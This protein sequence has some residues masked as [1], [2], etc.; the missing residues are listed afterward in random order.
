LDLNNS[1]AR[2]KNVKDAIKWCEILEKEME[3]AKQTRT[4]IG[5]RGKFELKS[6][7]DGLKETI[8]FNWRI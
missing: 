7:R 3:H 2:E 8:R 1:L 6:R 4:L 5:F